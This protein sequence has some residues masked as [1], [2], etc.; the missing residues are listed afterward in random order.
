[1]KVLFLN[2]A[3]TF[4]FIPRQIPVSNDLDIILRNEVS[5]VVIIQKLTWTI[6]KN[7]VYVT[8]END[9]DFV[10]KNKYEL[11]IQDNGI[12]IYRGKLMFLEENTDLQNYDNETQSDKEYV[13]I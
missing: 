10:T 1:M 2:T 6:T 4:P 12:T 5:Q 11:E 13:Y 7:K 8:L 9:T 3:F